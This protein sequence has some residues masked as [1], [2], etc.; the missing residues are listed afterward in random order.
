MQNQGEKTDL[1]K[2]ASI[3]FVV[4]IYYQN[5]IILAEVYIKLD[6]FYYGWL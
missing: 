4:V 6:C 1:W 5:A 2:M 3:V